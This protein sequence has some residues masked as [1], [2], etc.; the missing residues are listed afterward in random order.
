MT[1]ELLREYQR[2]ERLCAGGD[3][4]GRAITL[5][6]DL[7]YT[8][9]TAL[10]AFIDQ[11]LVRR[12]NDFL[13]D[14]DR[15]VILDCGANIG[16]TVLHYKRQFPAALITAFEPDPQFVPILRRNLA[17]NGADDVEVVEAAAWTGDGQA[18]WTMEGKDG[19]RLTNGIGHSE[20]VITV[21]T[22]DL[23]RYLD[24][25]ID[26]LKMDIEGAEFEVLPHIASRLAR[27]RNVIVE[28]HLASQQDYD[29]FA[30]VLTDLNGAGF[31]ISM[32]SFG[33][34]RDLTRRHVPAPLHSVQYVLVAGWRD[35][36]PDVSAE[37][38][39]VPYVGAAQYR[40]SPERVSSLEAQNQLLSRM[41]AEVTTG[42]GRWEVLQM[43][44]PFRHESGRCWMWNLPD[45][46]MPG[47][48]PASNDCPTV[49]LED[50]RLLGPGQA[51]HE[52]IRRE[53]GGRY[54]HWG[55]KLYLS[56][57]DNS[58]PNTNGRTYTAVCLRK[59]APGIRA[60]AS[61]SGQ[62]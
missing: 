6:W 20:Q 22:V 2:L 14:T 53:G 5:G 18:R 62:D 21:A 58:D 25:D 43:R 51:L 47:D 52:E 42:T 31:S 15:P 17:R 35:E 1:D 7:E 45:S 41:L 48:S 12:M 46:V 57:S 39:Y 19:S 23:A 56:T 29:A 60:Q 3:G 11:I 10:L 13:A 55:A 16:Y 8:S 30:R 28:C 50:V 38:T 27:V 9:P 26:L 54:S 4:P 61:E 32:N 37:Q 44:P 49:V 33:P 24:R 34:W 59:E 40:V 36:H